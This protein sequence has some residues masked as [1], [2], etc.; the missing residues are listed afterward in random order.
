MDSVKNR[1]KGILEEKKKL[2]LLISFHRR[3]LLTHNLKD[4]LDLFSKEIRQL[5]RAERV[6]VFLLDPRKEELFAKSATGLEPKTVAS[7]KFS[8][9]QGIAGYVVRAGRSV[10][11]KNAYKDRRF[12]PRFDELHGFR[13]GSVLAA[14][15]KNSG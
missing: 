6:T 13:T 1:L 5:L 4:T 7:L 8:V 2:Q 14:P 3:S 9:G 12:D 10:N 11:V 15:L